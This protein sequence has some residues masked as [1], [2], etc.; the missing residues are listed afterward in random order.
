MIVTCVY[1]H[2]KPETV[3][4]FINATIRNHMRTVKEPGNIR[5][6]FVQHADDPCRFMLY[7]VFDSAEAVDLHKT[8]EHYLEW[9]DTVAEFMADTR[10]GV[11]YNIIEPSD[12]TRW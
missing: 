8:T 7:E 2:V 12:R 6:D 1:I 9:R 10:K 11:R 5:F 4:S 3:D